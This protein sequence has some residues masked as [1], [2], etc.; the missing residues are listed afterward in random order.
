[1]EYRI[2]KVNVGCRVFNVKQNKHNLCK[3]GGD[4]GI[5]GGGEGVIAGITWTRELSTLVIPPQRANFCSWSH[6]R[7]RSQST[8][9]A[10]SV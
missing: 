4:G 7:G 6:H 2:A 3:V 8:V 10:S 1:M 9:I 5:V